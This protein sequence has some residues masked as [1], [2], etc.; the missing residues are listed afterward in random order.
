MIKSKFQIQENKIS[1]RKR[2]LKGRNINSQ[3]YSRIYIEITSYFDDGRMKTKRIPTTQWVK[4]QH[5]N[6]KKNDGEVS[7]KDPDHISKNNIINAIFTDYINQLQMREMGTWSPEFNTNNL[8]PLTDIFP[9]KSKTLTSY[10]DDYIEY[11]KSVGTTY[12]TLKVFTSVKN[13]I[14]NFEKYS[15]KQYNF[16]DINLTFSDNFYSFLLK[17][18]SS[19][20]IQ[21]TYTILITILNHFFERK[22]ELHINLSDKFRSKR[23]KHGEK[24]ENDAHP[25]SLIEWETLVKHNFKNEFLNL[26][27]TRFLLQASTG[28]RY[29]DLFSITPDKIIDGCIIYY[30]QKTK[31]KRNNRTEVALNPISVAILK[32]LDYDS[33]KLYVSNQKYNDALENMFKKL[34]TDYPDI[35]FDIYTSHDARDTFI[36]F[37]IESGVDIPTILKAVGQEDYDMLKKYFKNSQEHVKQSMKKIKAF[38]LKML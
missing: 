31:G 12:N 14:I 30:P 19:G 38:N 33:R 9:N 11:R 15:N 34:Q 28:M 1:I 35:K 6:S 32:P 21:K 20:T 22:E 8:L 2:I 7:N 24:S 29:S 3:G 26:T 16:E 17:E 23:F 5:W 4:P 18:L 13:R 10:I 25:L 37:L 36:T 27:K